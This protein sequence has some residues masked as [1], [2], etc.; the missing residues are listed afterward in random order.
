LVVWRVY[1]YRKNLGSI[2]ASHST[3]KSRFFRL[4]VI[5][6]LIIFVNLPLAI[7]ASYYPYKQG[8]VPYDWASVHSGWV[9]IP[10]P[11]YGAFPH[12]DSIIFVVSGFLVFAFF[13]TGHDAK[14]M[15][16]EWSLKLG[17]TGKSSTTSSGKGSLG[18]KASTTS[19]GSR[20]S[21]FLSGR[22]KSKTGDI[23]N[24]ESIS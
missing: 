9:V 7:H 4:L 21:L 11:T 24:D 20:F 10:V 3:T 14:D 12:W 22:K 17:L 6:V 2:M 13:G 15:Y 18:T 23:N 8:L 1:S 19:K 16:Q 5:S